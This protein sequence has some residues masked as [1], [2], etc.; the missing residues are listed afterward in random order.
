MFQADNTGMD[1]LKGFPPDNY[2]KVRGRSLSANTKISRNSSMSSTKLFVVYHKKMECNNA[3]NIDVH[4]DN[5]SPELSYE[6]FQEKALRVSK[7][8]KHPTNMRNQR[9]SLIPF[10]PNSQC[11]PAEHTYSIPIHG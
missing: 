4:I 11:V 8:A 1:I 9:D 7:A 6:T 5:F 10:K 3:M 2:N